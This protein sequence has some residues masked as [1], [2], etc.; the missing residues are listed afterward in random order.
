MSSPA[1]YPTT[2]GGV[3]GRSLALQDETKKRRIVFDLP[4]NARAIIACTLKINPIIVST[5]Q[6]AMVDDLTYLPQQARVPAC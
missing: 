6:A 5:L 2:P 3:W 1:F 4:N